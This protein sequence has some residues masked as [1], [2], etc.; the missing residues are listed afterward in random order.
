M[1]FA[2][3]ITCEA[4]ATANHPDVLTEDEARHLGYTIRQCGS[5]QRHRPH[6][7]HTIHP[8][9]SFYCGGKES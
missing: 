7:A 2:A 1:D 5:P 8:G 3:L 9:V 6:V 4:S